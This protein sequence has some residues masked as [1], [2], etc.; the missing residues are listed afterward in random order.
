MIKSIDKFKEANG[1]VPERI[2]I[3]R[4]G[5]SESQ[6]PAVLSTEC[7]S[8]KDALED[9]GYN[10]MKLIFLVVNKLCGAR[11][12]CKNG[13]RNVNPDRGIVVDKGVVKE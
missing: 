12:F 13:D 11:F 8:I 5:V 1:R 2:V 6:L 3:Y 4:D 10:D 7:G 9:G